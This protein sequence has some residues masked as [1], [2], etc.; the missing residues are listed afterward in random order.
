MV[1]DV[2][3]YLLSPLFDKHRKGRRERKSLLNA[4]GD[5]S[6]VHKSQC[7]YGSEGGRIGKTNS[8]RREVGK[9][10]KMRK[11][12]T[13]QEDKRKIM[14]DDDGLESLREH[15]SERERVSDIP[16]KPR[17]TRRALGFD[18]ATSDQ[19]QEKVQKRTLDVYDQSTQEVKK[20][21]PISS[22]SGEKMTPASSCSGGSQNNS[23][24][25]PRSTQEVR[26]MTPASSRLGGIRKMTHASSRSGRSQKNGFKN[27]RSTQEVRKMT[28]VPQPA[29][30]EE[31]RK[32]TPASNC[33]GGSQKIGFRNSRSTQEVRKM[34]LASSR[35]GEEVRKM[36]PASSYLGGSQNND[37]RN[38]RSTQEVR[39]MTPVSSRSGRS[40]KNG[41]R[42][43]RSTQE[44][45][46]MTHVPQVA[47]EKLEKWLQKSS[48]NVGSQK[49]D[50]YLKPL[51]R[52]RKMTLASSRSGEV[53]KMASKSSLNAGSSKKNSFQL[54][55]QHIQLCQK[56]FQ[57]ELLAFSIQFREQIQRELLESAARYR[58]QRRFK[59]HRR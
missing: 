8:E 21:T 1:L 22:R 35:S 13:M 5:K 34:T 52:I 4:G 26:K 49:N 24:R 43:P 19:Y 59:A 42:N 16:M 47:R 45:I 2:D 54:T 15:E 51:G 10:K 20:M 27:T 30:L 11:R 32:M 29:Q 53:R 50:S 44:V 46:K 36:T 56:K 18:I 39:K 40:Q 31:V 48:F 9:E 7:D 12:G 55:T 28:P 41:F 6:S 23:F 37:F 57:R 17:G 14:D 33:S 38:P 25:N 58:E 3:A